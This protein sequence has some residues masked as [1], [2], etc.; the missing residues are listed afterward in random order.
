MHTLGAFNQGT[1]KALLDLFSVGL[2]NICE[3]ARLTLNLPLNVM[4]R[5]ALMQCLLFLLPALTFAIKESGKC[6]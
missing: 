3:G 4:T 2:G 1:Q 5:A 6:N